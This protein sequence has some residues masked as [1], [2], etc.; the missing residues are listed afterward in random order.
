V[1]LVTTAGILYVTW[2]RQFTSDARDALLRE[3]K[4]AASVPVEKNGRP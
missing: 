2:A 4:H 3:E 1:F